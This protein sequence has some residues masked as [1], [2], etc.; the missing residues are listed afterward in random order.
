MFETLGAIKDHRIHIVHE[1][2]DAVC[3]PKAAARLRDALVAA[4]ATDNLTLEFVEAAGHSDS[5]PPISRAL[6]R[7]ADKLAD[8]D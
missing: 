2:N 3:L 8:S 7:A 6:R 4:G 1:R 5:E